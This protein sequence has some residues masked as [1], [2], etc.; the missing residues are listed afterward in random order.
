M[1]YIGIGTRIKHARKKCDL[2]QADM[3]RLTGISLSFYGHIERG[4]R[5]MSIETLCKISEVLDVDA[6]YLLWGE[7]KRAIDLRLSDAER[8]AIR[9]YLDRQ[10][11][12][13]SI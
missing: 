13:L 7:S 12:E 9:T 11:R 2:T 6:H 5:I 8:E 4:S 3:A 1:D 10:L